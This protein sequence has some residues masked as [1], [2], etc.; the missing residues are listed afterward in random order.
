MARSKNIKQNPIAWSM[1]A[2]VLAVYAGCMMIVGG[3]LSQFGFRRKNIGVVV[4][5][6]GIFVLVLEWPRPKRARG[7]TIPRS[8]Q[9]VIG[10][11]VNTLGPLA[12][13]YFFRFVIWLGACI[14]CFFVFPAITGGLTLAVAA[15][16]YL[17][18]AFKGENWKLLEPR[19]SRGPGQVLEAPSKPPPRLP[20]NGGEQQPRDRKPSAPNKPVPRP[21]QSLAATTSTT[22]DET[23]PQRAVP[24]PKPK[25]RP[26]K[27]QTQ[28]DSDKFADWSW[29]SAQDPDSG[30]LYYINV[31]TDE[32]TWE[33][34]PHWDEYL[35]LYGEPQTTYDA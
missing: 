18:A 16:V 32:T 3:F 6:L 2:N 34:P 9:F 5:V 11:M 23:P 13:N 31:K 20:A 8:G 27:K 24:V 1:W 25:P 21:G 30:Q 7:N 22:V 12:S 33:K 14:P 4:L 15:L 19:Q 29:E 28:P 35:A 17:L 26:K 10:P